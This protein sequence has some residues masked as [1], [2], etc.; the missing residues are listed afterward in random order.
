MTNDDVGLVSR[1]LYIAIQTIKIA[2]S[3]A[4]DEL[5]LVLKVE[6]RSGMPA[7]TQ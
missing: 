1:A 5:R 6:N 7:S 2:R 3:K 4:M